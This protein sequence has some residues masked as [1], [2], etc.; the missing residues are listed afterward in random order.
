MISKNKR[1]NLFGNRT[2]WRSQIRHNILWSSVN[3]LQHLIA[4]MA[5]TSAII[6]IFCILEI[7]AGKHPKTSFSDFVIDF[8]TFAIPSNL[9]NLFVFGLAAL[10]YLA[11]PNRYG[12]LSSTPWWIQFLS[13]LVLEDMVNYWFHRASHKLEWMWPFH[14]PHHS[15][16]YMSA[17]II[18]RNSILIHLMFP[19][20]YFAA[21]LVYF[22][23]GETYIWYV[24]IKTAVLCAAHSELRWD[25]I[26]YR[27][28]FLHPLAW[29][30]ERTISTP[31]TH[32]AH[33]A[34][35]NDDGIGNF[36]G[37]YGNLLFL[38]DILFGTALITRQYPPK[39]GLKEERV[40]G[41]T[42]W[43]SQLFYPLFSNSTRKTISNHK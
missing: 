34:E 30:I 42:A 26:L 21:A 32:F 15:S 24:M 43:Y 8:I 3:M 33:H 36:N 4:L 18:R 29:V 41:A 14:L 2:K 38:W 37:N 31:A 35:T 10:T 25:A 11:M 7:A 13:F 6:V 39:V 22:G 28:K 27:H 19:N 9:G 23:F 40:E 12:A 17:R 20:L 16:D 5:G 1:S